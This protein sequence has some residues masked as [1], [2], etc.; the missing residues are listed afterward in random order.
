MK[1]LSIPRIVRDIRYL[2]AFIDRLWKRRDRRITWGVAGDAQHMA[3]F[4]ALHRIVTFVLSQPTTAAA[5]HAAIRLRLAFQHNISAQQESE[6][7]LQIRITEMCI[8]VTLKQTARRPV[9]ATAH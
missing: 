8:T 4:A 1:H 2:S 6:I 3:D 5:Y 9:D 7:Q